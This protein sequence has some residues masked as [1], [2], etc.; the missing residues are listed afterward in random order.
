MRGIQGALES[1]AITLGTMM[2]TV[3]VAPAAWGF[4]RFNLVLGLGLA[5]AFALSLCVCWS[6][7]IESWRSAG[8]ENPPVGV[9]Q[10]WLLL[11]AVPITLVGSVLDCS[12]FRGCTPMCAFLN[13]CAV[14]ALTVLAVLY[15]ALARRGSCSL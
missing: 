6:N 8:L 9:P 15:L 11:G 10:R 13:T 5:L 4:I 2:A 1:A 12:G 3:V 7:A 14:P